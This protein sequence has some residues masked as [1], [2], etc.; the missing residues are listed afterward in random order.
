MQSIHWS[1]VPTQNF[2]GNL[3]AF[4]KNGHIKIPC[5]GTE[6]LGSTSGCEAVGS[7][8]D[9]TSWNR[10]KTRK[11]IEPEEDG[12]RFHL[13]DGG[14]CTMH[15]RCDLMSALPLTEVRGIVPKEGCLCLVDGI[16]TN[17]RTLLNH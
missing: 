4:S 5:V 1:N 7:G 2:E 12:Y 8:A 11:G 16:R 9:V 15:S 14:I 13:D 6:N 10:N 3:S 17:S